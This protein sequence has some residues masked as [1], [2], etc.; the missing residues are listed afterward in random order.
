M[1]KILSRLL[2][3]PALVFA[4][5][6][7]SFSQSADDAL[8][9]STPGL[10][11]GARS[12]GLAGAFTGVASDYSAIFSNPA[13]LAQMSHNEFS[14]GLESF[15]YN[16]SSTFLGNPGSASNSSTDLNTLGMVYQ[17]PT[18][19]GSLVL[20]L[21]FNR[22]SDF[23]TALVF[24]AFNPSS[25][26]IPNLA[27][28][29]PNLAYQLYLTGQ[30]GYTP[31]RDSL[32][33]RGNVLEGGGVNNWSAAIAAEAARN[34]YVGVTVTFISGSYSYARDYNEIDTL[35][36]YNVANYDTNFA[37]SSLNLSQSIN[38]ELSGFTATLGMLY[39]FGNKSRFGLSVKLPTW[40][41]VRENYDTFGTSVFDVPDTAGNY[42]YTYDSPFSQRYDVTSPFV[43]SAGA[44]TDIADLMIAA[45]ADYTDWTQ[46]S[47]SSQDFDVSQ[48]NANIK[49]TF[50]ST[51]NLHIGA[52]Y[53]VASITDFGLRLRGGYAYLPSP[54]KGD[55]SSFS[56][57]YI[58]GGI[59]LIF[60]DAIGLNFS[61]V[62]G[63][64]DTY[65]VNYSVISAQPNIYNPVPP[66]PK[67]L[68][69][70]TQNTIMG[71]LTYRF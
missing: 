22:Q 69:S 63:T 28:T 16:N 50:Q 48:L 12:T 41:S 31:F 24:N 40:Y 23:T 20:A 64:W 52:E 11:V 34:L 37:L 10:G 70:I 55:P 27:Q 61:Y 67:T 9:L 29:D 30:N 15:S 60:E 26:I 68:E 65:H 62:H 46:M 3:V 35:D 47:F 8:R 5:S 45:S 33:Q 2:C 43:F 59:G 56:Q 71:T 49:N 44:S 54:Y 1:N 7:F 17:I 18:E 21:G 57:K 42:S 13:G 36:K 14:L 4:L 19:R 32:Q 38:S 58:T 66:D 25:S 6:S 53:D 51:L 39:K